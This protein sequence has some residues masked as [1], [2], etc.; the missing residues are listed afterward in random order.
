MIK[1]GS[2]K[3]KLLRGVATR[4]IAYIRRIPLGIPGTPSRGVGLS[5]IEAQLI[6]PFG[7]TAPASYGLAVQIDSVTGQARIINSTDTDA[8]GALVRVYPTSDG[9]NVNPTNSGFG[10]G[11]P[12]KSGVVDIMVRGYMTVALSNYA[13]A[14]PK[15]NGTVYV[16]YSASA[17]NHVLGGFEASASGGNTLALPDKWYFTG[18]CDSS[19]NA[20]IAINI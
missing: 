20:E 6:T 5:T 15:K 14:P 17:G 18:G 16:W 10:A 4:D 7:A 13:A 9:G 19:G 1:N 3:A 11:I 12:P 8:Y 2:F